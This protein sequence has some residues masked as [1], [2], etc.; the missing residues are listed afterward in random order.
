MNSHF[1]RRHD[2]GCGCLSQV[3][4]GNCCV[5][6]NIAP[7]GA[8][9]LQGTECATELLD[10]AYRLVEGI[11]HIQLRAITGNAIRAVKSRY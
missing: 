4:Q 3:G 1:A 6:N 11:R 8:A 10:L 5:K 9:E 2:A 7:K